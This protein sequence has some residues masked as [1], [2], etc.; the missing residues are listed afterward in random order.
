VPVVTDGETETHRLGRARANDTAGP[1]R[2]RYR[3]LA[4]VAALV[5]SA[6]VASSAHYPVMV[7]GIDS[8]QRAEVI[9]DVDRARAFFGRLARGQVDYY[10]FE[11]EA[12]QTITF[13]ILV[14]ERD[15]LRDLRP[16]VV[17]AGP[18]LDDDCDGLSVDAD[19][20]QRVVISAAPASVYE[21]YTQSYYWSYAEP[22]EPNS[23][24]TLPADG[25]YLIAVRADDGESEGPYALGFG[26]EHRFSIPEVLGFPLQWVSARLWYFS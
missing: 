21:G 9:D 8:P 3:R 12:E 5:V 19:G 10:R 23:T 16:E 13:E 2:L 1:G 20:C 26:N 11:G 6:A 25:T 18:G 24:L 22:G 15:E 7:A 17:V 14:P 4:W